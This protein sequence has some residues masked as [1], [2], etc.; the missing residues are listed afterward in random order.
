[1]P[2]ARRGGR[3]GGEPTGRGNTSHLSLD[4]QA[5]ALDLRGGDVT[6]HGLVQRI[7]SPYV[8]GRGSSY[9]MTFLI[10]VE[11]C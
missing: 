7:S 9:P 6:V 5:R 1:M 4:L 11:V 3:T 10:S 8:T 2:P